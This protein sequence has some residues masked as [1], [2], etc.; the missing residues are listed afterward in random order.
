MTL[1]DEPLILGSWSSDSAGLDIA[2]WT[3][4]GHNWSRQSSTGTALA[5]N[6]H[7]LSV[8]RAVGA[9]PRGIA[10]AGAVVQM[11]GGEVSLEPALWRGS[12]PSSW[13]R[14]QLPSTGTGEA[15]GVRC[16]LDSC[17]AAGYVDD[18]LA[19]WSMDGRDVEL[20]DL[21]EVPMSSDTVAMVAPI[22]S[23]ASAVLTTSAQRSLVLR[24]DR[25]GWVETLGPSATAAA[26]AVADDQTYAITTTPDGGAGLWP[27]DLL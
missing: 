11:G 10:L 12:S 18:R 24:Q 8:I 16:R 5:S 2:V 20:L 19:A 3:V 26:W 1:H 22:G 27:P 6:E 7:A 13:E 15:T 4:Q 25:D 17:L 14:V 23:E 21:P 9:D